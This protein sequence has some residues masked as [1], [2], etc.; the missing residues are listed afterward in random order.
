ME[1]T[2]EMNSPIYDPMIFD[3]GVKTKRSVFST[4]SA[5]SRASK[6]KRMK[7]DPYPSPYKKVNSI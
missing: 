7:L 3:N 4:N 1:Q 5:G 2:P 6:C